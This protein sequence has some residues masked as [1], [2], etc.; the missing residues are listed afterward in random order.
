MASYFLI[1]L[2]ILGSSPLKFSLGWL[3]NGHLT[4]VNIL[5]NISHFCVSLVGSTGVAKKGRAGLIIL[6][7]CSK[8]LDGSTEELRD[9]LSHKKEKLSISAVRMLDPAIVLSLFKRMTD[10]VD[11]IF[12][13]FKITI[14]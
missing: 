5:Q 10:E 8:T 12:L 2:F 11:P 7:D 3:T 13:S 1:L 14:L 9:A 6:H 4:A